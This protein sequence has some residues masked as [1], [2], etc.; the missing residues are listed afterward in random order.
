[1]LT[2]M[3]SLRN[4]SVQCA[5]AGARNLV[6]RQSSEFATSDPKTKKG[7]ERL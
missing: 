7:A 5:K 6:V 2:M 1:M 4:A 3:L